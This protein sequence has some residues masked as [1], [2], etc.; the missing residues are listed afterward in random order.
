MVDNTQ[1]DP[2]NFPPELGT[3]IDSKKI[4]S[5]FHLLETGIKK[6][7]E[8]CRPIDKTD[9]KKVV[10]VEKQKNDKMNGLAST[11]QSILKSLTCL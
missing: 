7:L 8:L 2:K 5:D 1:I 6:Y 3:G 11:V 4:A 10:K 9:A